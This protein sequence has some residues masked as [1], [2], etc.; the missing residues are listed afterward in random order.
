MKAWIVSCRSAKEAE[1]HL[2]F[3]PSWSCRSSQTSR[4]TMVLSEKLLP[5]TRRARLLR[6][7]PRGSRQPP[8]LRCYP[9]ARA[10]QASFIEQVQVFCLTF[11]FLSVRVPHSPHNGRESGNSR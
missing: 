6:S 8:P 2:D 1:R 11:D 4:W 10:I 5:L 9:R 7:Q 3:L